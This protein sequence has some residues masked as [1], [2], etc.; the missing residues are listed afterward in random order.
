MCGYLK[1]EGGVACAFVRTRIQILHHAR[2]QSGLS[3]YIGIHGCILTPYIITVL[4]ST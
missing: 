4:L 1:S 2:S 3:I